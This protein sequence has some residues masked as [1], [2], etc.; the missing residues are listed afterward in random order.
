MLLAMLLGFGEGSWEVVRRV[1]GL[2]S[3]CGGNAL[4]LDTSVPLFVVRHA[5]SIS[6]GVT[7]KIGYGAGHG[8]RSGSTP[9]PGRALSPQEWA[10]A[11]AAQRR[12][13]PE[14]ASAGAVRKR[15]FDETLTSSK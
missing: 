6:T 15:S 7:A 14:K 3:T 13:R 4:S 11:R 5:N 12:L 9:A 8:A 2:N 1:S 10:R